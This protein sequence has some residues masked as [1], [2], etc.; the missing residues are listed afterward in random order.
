MKDLPLNEDWNGIRTELL[1]RYQILRDAA[2]AMQSLQ[3]GPSGIGELPSGR[4]LDLAA[5][6]LFVEKAQKKLTDRA[7][8]FFRMGYLAA[9]FAVIILICTATVV[10]RRPINQVVGGYSPK[11]LTAAYITIILAKSTTFGALIASAV[12]LLIYICRACLHEGT[13]CVNRRHAMRFGRL[14]IYLSKGTL[15]L[16]DLEKAFKWSDEFTTAFKDMNPDR[17]GPKSPFAAIATALKKT[18]K[19]LKKTTKTSRAKDK[20]LDGND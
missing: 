17:V 4:T 19:R 8:S 18:A 3:D 20:D 2:A 14:F 11:D 9:G 1:S 7:D 13:V 5:T 15:D 10:W 12:A 16:K 6:D